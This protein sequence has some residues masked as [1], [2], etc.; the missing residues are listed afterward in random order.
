MFQLMKHCSTML[1]LTIFLCHCQD[2][3]PPPAPQKRG[4]LWELPV[5]ALE[6][7]TCSGLPAGNPNKLEH[8]NP[9]HG[10]FQRSKRGKVK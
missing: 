8:P 10:K 2:V 6:A 5:G 3:I 4:P 1:Y 9:D 7:R